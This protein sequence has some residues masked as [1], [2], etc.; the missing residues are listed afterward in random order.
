MLDLHS[1]LTSNRYPGRCVGV[2]R[3]KEGATLAFYAITGRS[4]SSRERQLDLLDSGELAVVSVSAAQHDP[5]R[6][7]VAATSTDHHVILGNGEQVAVVASKTASG[8]APTEALGDLS[9]EPDAPY[10]TPRITAVFERAANGRIV[11]GSARRSSTGRDTAD[12]ATVSIGGLACG[13][14]MLLTTYVSDGNEVQTGAPYIEAQSQAA[15][16]EELLAEV[17][18]GLSVD[19]RV[20][21]AVFDP[22]TGPRGALVVHA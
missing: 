5:L 20:A 21:A 14:V 10:F 3:V 13:D 19:Y 22:Q 7:Y 1:V 18:S 9:Y 4:A 17:W 8:V 16:A 15:N 12:I 11:L 6:H 2:A